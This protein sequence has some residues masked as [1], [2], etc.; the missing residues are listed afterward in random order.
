MFTRASSIQSIPPH[1][2]PLT[3]ILILSTH[4]HHCLPGSF[5]HSGFPTNILYTLLLS[6]IRATFPAHCILL[7][8]TIPHTSGKEYT[9]CR[10]SLFSSPEPPTL[11][12]PL[13]QILPSAPCSK[14]PS[15]HV[16]PSVSETKFHIYTEP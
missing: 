3:S 9:L 13:V 14:T 7:D 11:Q 15:F 8:L 4:L 16:H 5:P 2:I 1:P 10:P 6:S 12:L